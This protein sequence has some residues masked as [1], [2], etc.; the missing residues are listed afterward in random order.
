MYQPLE[1]LAHN[2]VFHNQ[3]LSILCRFCY[4]NNKI[5]TIGLRLHYIKHPATLTLRDVYQFDYDAAAAGLHVLSSARSG[6]VPPSSWLE[7]CLLL[8]MEEIYQAVE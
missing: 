2:D 4:F 6:S 5:R 1:C 8:G 3:L 7:C